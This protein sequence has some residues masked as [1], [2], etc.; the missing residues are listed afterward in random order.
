MRKLAILVFLA[1][2]SACAPKPVPA[3]VVVAPKFPEFIRPRIPP[4]LAGTAPAYNQDRGWTFL[5]AG[6]LRMAEREFDMALK[7]SAAFYPAENGLG[8][9]ELA[10]KDARA[11]L[12]HFDRALEREPADLSGLMGKAQALFT[13]NRDIEALPVLEAALAIDPSLS[14]VARRI[15]VLRF[16]AQQDELT[17]ARQAGGAGR[18]DESVSIYRK[19][20]AGSP[21]S[22]FL[23]REIAA[24]ERRQ[25]ND[26]QAL[27]HLRRAVA[28]EPADG[29]SLVQIG[30]ILAARGDLDAAVTAY[31]EAL[32]AEPN[33]DVDAKLDD[34]RARAALARLPEAYRAI[35]RAPQITRGDLAAL[36]GQRLSDLLQSS[37]RRDAV[38]ITD[39]A[40]HWAS[41]WIV[42]VARAGVMEPYANHAFQPRSIVRRVDLA[43]V[44]NRLLMKVVEA[45]P[46]QPHPWQSAR[47]KFAD[48]AP[49]HLA[50]LAASAAVASGV[51]S[52]GPNGSFQPGRLVSGQDAIEALDRVG[53]LARGDSTR[54]KS[55]R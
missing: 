4:V 40:N 19:A 8:Y 29:S 53:S 24:V 15:E 21:D 38:L 9:V 51:L 27:E 14:D 37:R 23:Y 31:T 39:I 1:V 46:N 34:V 49:G 12:P 11:A 55:A 50:Y 3:P 36:V 25:G 26:E 5:Q 18:L 44:V 47:L 13:L 7:T 32:A 22:A 30:D 48:L 42:T 33:L 45:A 43:Q 6:D 20:I 54:A 28:L 16:R 17:R 10:R 35:D 2:A 41:S 52:T